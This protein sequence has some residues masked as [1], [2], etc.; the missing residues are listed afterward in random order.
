VIGR[1]FAL[2]PTVKDW[3][4]LVRLAGLFAAGTVAFLVIRPIFVPDSFGAIGHYRA[5][6]V[7]EARDRSLNF[8]DGAACETCHSD[9]VTLRQQKQSRHVNIRC[10]SC[11]GPLGDHVATSGEKKPSLP[12]VVSLCAR[13]HERS[14]GR[15]PQMPQVQTAEHSGGEKCSTCHA[16][17]APGMQ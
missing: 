2:R 6:A 11:H 8:A 1:E 17:H 15:P 4:H 10:Q 5:A 12:D 9:V 16:P 7:V 14:A 13:C 3:L